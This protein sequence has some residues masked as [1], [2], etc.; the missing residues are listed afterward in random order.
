M[1]MLCEE[2]QCL[3]FC[4]FSFWPM[5]ILL[6]ERIWGEILMAWK[7]RQNC[8]IK[9]NWP[10]VILLI[11]I[12]FRF[13]HFKLKSICYKENQNI[14]ELPNTCRWLNCTNYLVK[15]IHQYANPLK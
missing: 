5:D 1:S 14:R 4:D 7:C 12:A 15:F 2:E 6:T 3:A 8:S 13:E 10:W 9:L 11:N